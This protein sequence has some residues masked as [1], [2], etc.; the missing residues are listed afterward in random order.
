MKKKIKKILKSRILIFILGGILFSTISVYAV[1]Y[2]PSNQVTYDN[3][4]S[5][6]ESADVQGAIDELYNT[7]S[8]AI[9][10]GNN[11]YYAFN[12]SRL[13]NS[14][15]YRSDLNG[16]NQVTLYSETV[17]NSYTN[18]SDIYVT[19]DYIYYAYNVLYNSSGSPYNSYIYR[20][21][22]NGQNRVSLYSETA[23]NNNTTIDG[24]YVSDNY[25]Y[26]TYNT[27]YSN[28]G[29]RSTYIKKIDLN[30]QNV[31]TIKSFETS[32]EQYSIDSIFIK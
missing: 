22:L 15:I 4:T 11:I 14:Y 16:Q 7:C 24:I 28:G 8:S 3:K 23:S 13:Y 27:Y 30:G 1:T 10:S 31:T 21:D 19:K 25:I 5:G 20:S 2:F 18:I 17:M 32:S 9:K 6:L 12:N 29:H 26:F